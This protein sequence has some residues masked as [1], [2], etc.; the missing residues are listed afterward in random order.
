MAYYGWTTAT[1]AGEDAPPFLM[2][3]PV[4]PCGWNSVERIFPAIDDAQAAIDE[5]RSSMIRG[6]AL[7]EFSDDL[8]MSGAM[9]LAN[10]QNRSSASRQMLQLALEYRACRIEA[11]HNSATKKK[12]ET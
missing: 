12:D 8:L 1:I 11:E 3:G 10:E 6:N 9:M 7:R 2:Q 5:Q 4:D